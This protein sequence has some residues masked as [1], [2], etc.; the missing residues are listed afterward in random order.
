MFHFKINGWLVQEGTSPQTI[1][2]NGTQVQSSA[3]NAVCF[4]S[5]IKVIITFGRLR[6]KPSAS[7][8]YTCQDSTSVSSNSS[9]T[10]FTELKD[11]KEI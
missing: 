9:G 2:L 7:S 5:L 11:K 10:F 1:N 8:N 6:E 4:T 3:R